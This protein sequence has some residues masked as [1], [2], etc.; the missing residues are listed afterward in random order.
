L[1]VGE[2]VVRSAGWARD[3]EDGGRGVYGGDGGVHGIAG[4]HAGEV[5]VDLVGGEGYG[6]EEGER[7]E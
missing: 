1:F 7:G 2:Q 4:A 3:D 6:G 5:D